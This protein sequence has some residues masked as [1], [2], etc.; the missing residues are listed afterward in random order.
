MDPGGHADFPLRKPNYFFGT[1]GEKE[2]ACSRQYC[3]SAC[4]SHNFFT[5]KITNL[6]KCIVNFNIWDKHYPN[7]TEAHRGAFYAE[8]PGPEMQVISRVSYSD[9]GKLAETVPG[10]GC[11]LLRQVGQAGGI[12]N[13]RGGNI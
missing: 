7:T 2:I 4:E 10:P 5:L 11:R 13:E 12:I 6:I 8:P 9:S 3:F 1:V